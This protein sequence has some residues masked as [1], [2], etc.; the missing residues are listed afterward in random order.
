LTVF[1]DYLDVAA[2]AAELA[3]A[4]L[5][6]ETPTTNSQLADGTPFQAA[7]PVPL[8]ADAASVEA[9]KKALERNQTTVEKV[10]AGDAATAKCKEIGLS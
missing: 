2:S 4:I 10:C 8:Y 6:G 3:I 5:G 9:I 7:D 1:K